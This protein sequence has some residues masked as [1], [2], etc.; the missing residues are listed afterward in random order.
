MIIENL[1]QVANQIESERGI[2][3]EFLYEALEQALASACRKHIGDGSQLECK[4]DPSA[5]TMQ[6]YRVKEV[7][8]D[9]FSESTEILINEAKKINKKA[10]IGDEVSVEFI[11]TDF[12]RIAA[13]IAK[14]V[15]T[16]RLREAERDS[17]YE[18]FESKVGHVVNGTVQQIENKSYLINLGRTES[19]LGYHDQ[20]PGEKFE[21]N[22]IIRVYVTNVDRSNKRN[23]ISISR[24]HSGLLQALFESEIPEIADGIIDVMSVAREPGIRAKV[25]V[26]TNNPSIGAV[27][28]C[29]G[30]MGGRIQTIIKELGNE[31]IDVLEWHED[32]KVY[33]ANSLKPADISNVLLTDQENK[34]ATVVVAKD[35]LSLA[36]GKA[37][38][39]VRLSVNLTGWKLNVI[40]EEEFNQ[41][42]NSFLENINTNQNTDDKALLDDKISNSKLA[43]AIANDVNLEKQKQIE[44]TK[45]KLKEK[46]K[47]ISKQDK[48]DMKVSV[49][50]KLLNVKT[51]DLI[52]KAKVKGI[53]IKSNRSILSHE[54]VKEIK[55][56]V[57]I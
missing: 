47:T 11:P 19:I 2:K 32:I 53:E 51:A 56:K 23:M 49:L 40:S 21:L 1:D 52:E 55:E 41:N 42:Q 24:S 45:E 54:Q 20:I 15:I 5:G 14:Q 39:N 38:V 12:G 6:F 35:Q 8:D 7:V 37:G 9:I 29:V 4:L 3:K 34:Q 50:A 31:K 36:I 48:N 25:A 17:V 26:K 10:D 22:E 57:F 28:T 30:Q 13:Q 44:V 16:Q 46:L 18:E 27:G 33:I 43:Q